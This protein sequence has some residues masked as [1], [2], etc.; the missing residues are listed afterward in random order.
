MRVVRSVPGRSIVPDQGRGPS[1]A[2]FHLVLAQT[3]LE[4]VAPIGLGLVLDSYFGW[5]PW[6]TVAGVAVGLIGGIGHMVYLVN[7][8]REE[9]PQPGPGPA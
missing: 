5:R 9:P 2:Q 3:G 6:S 7:H 4:M 1:E 8:H